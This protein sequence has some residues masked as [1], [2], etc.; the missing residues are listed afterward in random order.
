M[1]SIIKK[2][3]TLV[4]LTAAASLLAAFS[5][6]WVLDGSKP[7]SQE[8]VDVFVGKVSAMNTTPFAQPGDLCITPNGG[9]ISDAAAGEEWCGPVYPSGGLNSMNLTAGL[10]VR[11]LAFNTV[12]PLADGTSAALRGALVVPVSAP[13]PGSGQSANTTVPPQGET[14]L[15]RVIAQQEVARLEAVNVSAYMRAETGTVTDGNVGTRACMS[16]RLLRV[17]LVGDFPH[18]VIAGLAVL[19]GD[20]MPD[21]TVHG[22]E[23][24][25]DA[26]TGIACETSVRTGAVSVPDGFVLLAIE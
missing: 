17:L 10:E 14:D 16:G 6:W 22:V 9:E 23:I 2:P 12:G 20:A 19:K 3:A 4:A 18:I 7:V 26:Q 15:A 13:I 5:V 11:V 8:Q 24:T 25:A 1:T 21:T